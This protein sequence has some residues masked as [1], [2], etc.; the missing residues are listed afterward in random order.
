MSNKNH[1]LA[2]SLVSFCI[3][4]LIL[5]AAFLLFFNR[6][7][8]FDQYQ[9]WTYKPTS[10][11]QAIESQVKF[12]PSGDFIFRA[13][14]PEVEQAASFNKGCPRQEVGNPILGCYT[15]DNRIYIY[16][17]TN[18][19]LAGMEEVTAA[20][21]MLHAA[22]ARMSSSEQQ[23]LGVEL[24][25]AYD[26]LDNA[27]LKQRMSYYQRTEPGEF[28]NELHS[29]LGTEFA[30]LG[31]DLEQH[32]S[33]YFDRQAVLAAHDQYSK[34]Y[35]GLYSRSNTLYTAMQTLASSI[36]SRSATYNTQLAQLSSDIDSFNT[37]ARSGDFSSQSQFDSQR[38]ALIARSNQLDADREAINAD[39]DTYNNDYNEYQQIASQI[40]VLNNSIDSFNSLQQAPSV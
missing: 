35:D 37:R 40:Q 33:Q 32:Y 15:T 13:T 18:T 34:V 19:Q 12:T 25:A 6:Q 11:V 20:H 38:A 7:Y 24:Q 14:H 28:I 3:T 29:I 17:I 31:P 2:R 8:L 22:W 1:S 23:S 39:I 36:Q 5:A 16:S 9:V 10:A 21:E 27:D 4:L 30:N 26:K